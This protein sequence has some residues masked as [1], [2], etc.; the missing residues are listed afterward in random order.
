MARLPDRPR[1]Y[2]KILPKQTDAQVAEQA[3]SQALEDPVQSAPVG[4]DDFQGMD[5]DQFLAQPQG[6]DYPQYPTQSFQT[7]PFQQQP[8]QQLPDA[9]LAPHNMTPWGPTQAGIAWGNF[10]GRND[11]GQLEMQVDALTDQMNG[12]G[13]AGKLSI[14]SDTEGMAVRA[15]TIF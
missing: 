8:F 13:H 15:L 9:M 10:P 2:R 3:R 12:M 1:Q 11:D 6:L 4:T 14:A 7:Q 5:F